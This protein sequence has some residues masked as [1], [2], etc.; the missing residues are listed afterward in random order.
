MYT[1]TPVSTTVSYIIICLL[2]GEIFKTVKEF[3]VNNSKDEHP[4]EELCCY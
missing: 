4:I 1:I 2:A 3:L